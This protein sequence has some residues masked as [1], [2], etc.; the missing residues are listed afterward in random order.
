MHDLVAAFDGGE[1]LLPLTL[2]I[3]AVGVHLMA[4]TGLVEDALAGG[5]V[6]RD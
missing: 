4:Q 3:C 1:D 5:D 6:F 2:N